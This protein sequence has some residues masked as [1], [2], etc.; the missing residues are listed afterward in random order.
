MKPYIPQKLP[1]N[2]ID[3]VDLIDDIS[4]ANRA[5]AKYDGYLQI[6]PNKELLLAPL[7][8][9]EAVLSSK[10]EGTQATFEDV[11]S[12]E[13]NQKKVSNYNDIEEVI[14]YKKAI[15]YAED[16]LSDLPLSGRLFKEIHK[17][18]LNG[19]RGRNKNPGNFRNGQVF[20]GKSGENIEN[21]TFIPPEPQIINEYISNLENYIHYDEKDVLVQLAILHAQFE[22]IH[23]FWDGN[24][25]VG[26]ILIPLFLF[27]KNVISTPMFYISEFLENNRKD[28]YKYLSLVSKEKEWNG[29]IKFFLNAISIQSNNNIQKIDKILSLYNQLKDEIVDIP[30]PKNSIKVLDFLFST[31]IFSAKLFIEKTGIEKRNVYRIIDFLSNKEIIFSDNKE[32][33]KTYSFDK[34]LKVIS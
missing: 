27:Y 20:I 4:K 14:N 31:P 13:A 22:I 3:W 26:R 25:R 23:P 28:Y 34:L 19:V 15:K 12:F 5:L 9:K 33:N 17:I 21:A 29:W 30:T 2:N 11:L 8:T 7:T 6:I 32:R 18:L 1:L 10:I 16:R 24:G